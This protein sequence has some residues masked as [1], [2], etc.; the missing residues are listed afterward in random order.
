MCY[1]DAGW[2]NGPWLGKRRQSKYVLWTDYIDNIADHSVAT[3]YH[4]TQEGVRAALVWGSQVMQRIG[5]QV[6]NAENRL[7]DAERMAVMAFFVKGWRPDQSS[8]DE[9]WRT[10]MLAQHH[11]SWIVPYNRLNRRGTWA[12][13]IALWTAA[14]C[15]RAD[16]VVD[17]SVAVRSVADAT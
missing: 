15:K 7:L 11:D 13:N 6:R 5:R 3:D 16:S 4:M 14:T 2:R 1:Q 12:D 17:A 9:A 10:L 8:I